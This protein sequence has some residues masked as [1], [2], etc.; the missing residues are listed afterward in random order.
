MTLSV[1][2]AGSSDEIDRARA[3]MRLLRADG[4]DVTSTWPAAVEKAGGVGNPRDAAHAQRLHWSSADVD[5]LVR[6]DVVWF[7]A[8]TAS[9][10]R[11]AYFE[12][13]YAIAGGMTAV[14]SGDTKQSIFTSF[15]HEFPTDDEALA[16]IQHLARRGHAI[17]ST[18]PA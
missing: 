4:I 9:P 7:L 3:A 10:G 16:F 1:Y 18:R 5:E 8:P 17:D 13:G 11:G 2:V 14:A 15:A 6:A 12:L